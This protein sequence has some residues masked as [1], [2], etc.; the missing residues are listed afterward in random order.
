MIWSW[1]SCCTPLQPSHKGHQRGCSVRQVAWERFKGLSTR[2]AKVNVFRPAMPYRSLVAMPHFR[3]GKDHWQTGQRAL[4]ARV[5]MTH[6]AIH[7]VSF[8]VTLS[9]CHHVVTH[10]NALLYTRHFDCFSFNLTC[11]SSSWPPSSKNT[12]LLGSLC[13]GSDD[14]NQIERSRSVGRQG[15]VQQGN[16]KVR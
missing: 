4:T 11:F 6:E 13:W 15:S 7:F 14:V 5:S 3:I 16:H 1:G 10:V 8:C 9:W 2:T 12:A